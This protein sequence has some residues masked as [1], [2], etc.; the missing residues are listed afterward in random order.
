MYIL[1]KVLLLYYGDFFSPLISIRM[2]I[3]ASEFDGNLKKRTNLLKPNISLVLC[4]WISVNL[5]E[6]RSILKKFSNYVIVYSYVAV[7]DF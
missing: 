4:Q 6:K 5:R 3:S 7:R 2:W 1:S